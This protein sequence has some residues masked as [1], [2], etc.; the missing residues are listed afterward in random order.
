MTETRAIY[1]YGHGP[2]QVPQIMSEFQND[3]PPKHVQSTLFITT[4]RCTYKPINYERF[5][6]SPRYGY[7]SML[8]F[9]LRCKQIK[10]I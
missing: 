6:I 4:R 2:F 9:M 5:I 10:I 8:I 1:G 3:L 7:F